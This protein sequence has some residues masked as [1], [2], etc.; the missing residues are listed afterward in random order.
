MCRILSGG[1]LEHLGRLGRAYAQAHHGW[2]TVLDTIFD[3]YRK[4]LA[5]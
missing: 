5:A 3:I 2:D 4:I 1:D